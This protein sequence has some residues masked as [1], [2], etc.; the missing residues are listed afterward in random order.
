MII[1][2]A[3]NSTGTDANPYVKKSTSKNKTAIRIG[4]AY[5]FSMIPVLAAITY[6]GNPLFV[7]LSS[8]TIFLV[9]STILMLLPDDCYQQAKVHPVF[10]AKI[11]TVMR[12]G[13]ITTIFTSLAVLHLLADPWAPIYYFVLWL[14]P[15]FTSF[16]FFMILRQV[17]QHGNGDRGWIT[18]TRVF[19]VNQF[20]NFCVFP[21]G[22]DYHLPHH[23]YS[24]VPHYRLKKLHALLMEYPEYKKDAINV[25]GYFRSPENPQIHPTVVDVLGDDYASKNFRGV[26]IDNTVLDDNEVEDKEGII[27]TGER[28]IQKAEELAREKSML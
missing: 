16:S 13:Y 15:I 24:T 14:V 5:V 17:V 20:I 11:S 22:Q 10:S 28:E 7:V 9:F 2:A 26:H 25:H 4:I 8:L 19:F 27:K 18:N 1:R 21:I 12:L 23:L 6:L 3:Y